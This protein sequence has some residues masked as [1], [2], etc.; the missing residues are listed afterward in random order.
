M[1]KVASLL[2]QGSVMAASAPSTQEVGALVLALAA[3]LQDTWDTALFLLVSPLPRLDTRQPRQVSAVLALLPLLQATWL[4]PRLPTTLQHHHGMV[5]RLR[6]RT[7]QRHPLGI[8]LL[9]RST[10]R[11]RRTTAPHLPPSAVLP[12]RRIAQRRLSTVLRRHNTAQ[13]ARSSLVVLIV[14]LQRLLPRRN[15]AQLAHATLLLARLVTSLLPHPDT[16]LRL[17]DSRTRSGH[18]QAR[19]TLQRRP[20]SR[21]QALRFVYMMWR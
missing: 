18:R 14:V 3:C 17:R 4:H 21:R 1:T 15:I 2:T 7:P 6:L 16:P 12:H 19:R 20:S 13:P 11:R 5:R 10:R 8:H 9:R